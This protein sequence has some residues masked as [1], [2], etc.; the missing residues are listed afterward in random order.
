MGGRSMKKIDYTKI[1]LSKEE[2]EIEDSIHEYVPTSRAEFERI[3]KMLEARRKDTV[4][5]VRINSSDLSLIK[6]KAKKMGIKYQ[7][8]ITEILHKIAHT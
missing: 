8:F 6:N 7:T 4:L 2:Q 5:N 3:K 1:K